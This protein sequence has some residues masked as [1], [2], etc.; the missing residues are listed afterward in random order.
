MGIYNEG[1]IGIYNGDTLEC[2]G[3]TVKQTNQDAMRYVWP[4]QQIQISYIKKYQRFARSTAQG[5][6]GSFTIGN[7]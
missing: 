5:G 4:N 7:L 6:G 3:G 2:H 1:Y